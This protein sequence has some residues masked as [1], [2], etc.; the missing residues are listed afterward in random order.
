MS[1]VILALVT[2]VYQA[3]IVR[4]RRPGPLGHGGFVVG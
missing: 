2:A 3:A 4:A 1:A